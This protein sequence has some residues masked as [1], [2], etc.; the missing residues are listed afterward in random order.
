MSTS[1]A[2]LQ[3]QFKRNWFLGFA[4]WVNAFDHLVALRGYDECD[5][6]LDL[7]L[8]HDLS[9][10]E[11]RVAERREGALAWARGGLGAGAR[12]RYWAYVEYFEALQSIVDQAQSL[13]S[14]AF[15]MRHQGNLAEAQECLARA[16][17]VAAEE[18][19]SCQA[20]HSLSD[21]LKNST[22]DWKAEAQ[23]HFASLTTA[24]DYLSQVLT[25]GSWAE[26]DKV[27]SALV[28]LRWA[29]PLIRALDSPDVEERSFAVRGL[30][31]LA[32]HWS[33]GQVASALAN[34]LQDQHWFIRW[35]SAA[36]MATIRNEAS[37]LPLVKALDDLD[38]DVRSQAAQALGMSEEK[39]AL[40]ALIKV[41]SDPDPYVR[42]TAAES[43]GQLGQTT[44]GDA[45]MNA[46]DDPD[47][48]VRCKVVRAL[49][50]LKDRRAQGRLLDLV[51]RNV[52][53]ALRLEAIH[54]LG[55]MAD[56]HVGEKLDALA[57]R[58]IG[59]DNVSRQLRKGLRQA[60]ARAKARSVGSGPA[61]DLLAQIR[62]LDTPASEMNVASLDQDNIE[63][64]IRL[65]S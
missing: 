31:Q 42:S 33:A 27:V 19:A 9:P 35:R 22:E 24:E 39:R 10:E 58:L 47:L 7:L 1:Y 37:L 49:A 62:F 25:H 4:Q 12:A 46:M 55:E 34:A 45:L 17:E 28:E 32:P 18:A 59:T 48:R 14:L 63:S 20:L 38:P 51:E 26:R 21:R 15:I 60:A 53:L 16:R 52:D 41:L 2:Q 5:K 57:L 44:V 11:T 50:L 61:D 40:P 65:L 30:E 23:R 13:V 64:Q 56:A 3:Q 54:A 8:T 36:A 6:L 29:D 43:L